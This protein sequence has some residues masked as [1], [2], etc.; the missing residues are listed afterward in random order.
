M[1]KIYNLITQIQ[2]QIAFLM[3]SSHEILCLCMYIILLE[4][5]EHDIL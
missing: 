5:I 3:Y 4:F 2:P 1:I